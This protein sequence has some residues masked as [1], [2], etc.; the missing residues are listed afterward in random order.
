VKGKEQKHCE[1]K[2]TIRKKGSSLME[3]NWE[4]HKDITDR[5]T[6]LQLQ[7]QFIK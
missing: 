3:G 6:L 5:I 4:V 1:R 2:E 7:K